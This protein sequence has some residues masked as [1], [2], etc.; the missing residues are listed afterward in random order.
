MKGFFEV[1]GRTGKK[2][3]SLELEM[4]A[5]FSPEIAL[6]ELEEE[7]KKDLGKPSEKICPVDNI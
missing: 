4:S 3:A 2:V 6:R 7:E 5:H 1:I